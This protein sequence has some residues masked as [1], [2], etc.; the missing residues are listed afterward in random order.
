MGGTLEALSGSLR[1]QNH[2]GPTLILATGFS[3]RYSHYSDLSEAP[4]LPF[5]NWACG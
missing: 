2:Q 5:Y 1:L 4:S 3:G